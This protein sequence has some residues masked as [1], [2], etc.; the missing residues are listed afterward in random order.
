MKAKKILWVCNVPIPLIAVDMDIRVPNIC[1]WLSGF[2]NS[3]QNVEGVE[4]TICFPEVGIKNLIKGKVGNII[5]Y[6]FSQPRVLGFLPF[7]DQLNTSAKMRTHLSVIINEVNPDILHVF[8][9]EYPHSALAI[10]IFGKP[11]NTVINIQGLT[12]VYWKHFNSGIP[13]S[14]IKK[15]AFSNIVRG[16]LE[17][18]AARLRKRGVFEIKA[19]QNAGHVIGR[20]DWDEACVKQINPNINYHFCNETLRESFYTDQWSVN[21]CEK[22]SIF[23]SQSSTPIKGL[24]F[25]ILALSEIV[26]KYPTTHLYIAGNN[27]I[28]SRTLL[29]RAKISS[30]ALHIKSLIQKYGLQDSITF[31]GPLSEHEMKKMYLKCNAFV[32]PSTIENSP[33]SLGEAMILGVPSI[34]SFVGGTMNMMTHGKEGFLY[35]SDAYYM[36]SYYIDKIFSNPEI[37]RNIGVNAMLH[38]KLTHCNE[39]NLNTLLRIYSEI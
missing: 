13:S 5:Y 22:Y 34:S 32:L 27:I 3:L 2:A 1:G 36:I 20:T 33:N 4:L 16:N 37:S 30:Y 9:T 26:K 8:G 35:Q 6:G 23:A 18:Q 12:S 31:T 24:H 10:E 39:Q 28:S 21:N 38:A 11:E 7:E 19:I 29:E 17:K 15:I 25:L 14:V